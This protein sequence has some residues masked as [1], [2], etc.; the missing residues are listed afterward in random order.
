MLEKTI[1]SV[2]YEMRASNVKEADIE[3]IMKRVENRFSEENIDTELQHLGYSKVFTVDY[4]DYMDYL[5]DN[6]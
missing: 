5:E 2:I 6:E 3:Y 4:D 1:L